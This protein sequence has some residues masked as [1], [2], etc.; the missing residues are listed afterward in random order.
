MTRP[1]K[2]KQLSRETSRERE[3]AQGQKIQEER[4]WEPSEEGEDATAIGLLVNLG[5]R[6]AEEGEIRASGRQ[7]RK[8][9]KREGGM[10]KTLESLHRSFKRIERKTAVLERSMYKKDG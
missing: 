6:R 10:S 2:R 1:S 5:P 8:S 3:K 9:E 4:G 7:R